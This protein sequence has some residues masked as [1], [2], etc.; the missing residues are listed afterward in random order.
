[1]MTIITQLLSSFITSLGFGIIVNVP[2]RVLVRCGLTGMFG[3]MVN[4]ILL[5]QNVSTTVSVFFGAVTVS[6]CSIIFARQAKVPTTTFNLPGI[7]PLVP[8]IS[9][10]QAIRSLMSGDYIMGIEL[11]TKTFTISITIALAIVVIEIFYRII[12]KILTK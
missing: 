3:W 2:R 12:M 10:Y 1:M 11:L 9:A 4:W 7:F 6:V 5:G 8:G